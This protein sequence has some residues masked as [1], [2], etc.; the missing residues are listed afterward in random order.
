MKNV[1][2]IT[3]SLNM[4]GAERWVLTLAANF[5]RV[6]THAILNTLGKFSDTLYEEAK[7]I[8][9]TYICQNEYALINK[10]CSEADVIISWGYPYLSQ[11]QVDKPIIEVSHSDPVW[12]SQTKLIKQTIFGATHFVGVSKT[13][14]SAFPEC[15]EATTIYNGI[16]LERLE[17]TK[18]RWDTREGWG[19]NHK[20]L[21]LYLGG[22]KTVK[23]P[24]VVIEAAK[25]LPPEYTVLYV[26]NKH[27]ES[28]GIKVIRPDTQVG[29][30]YNAADVLVMPSMYEGMPLVLLEA[31]AH[32][33]PTV[34]TEYSAYKELSALHGK[35]SWTTQVSPT[36][37]MLADQIIEAYNGLDTNITRKAQH[38]VYTNYTTQHMVDRWENY[39]LGILNDS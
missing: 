28:K 38:V 21:V 12:P 27:F 11:L 36:P 39:L 18:S 5:A 2:F 14:A 3:P 33:I 25:I 35:L 6:R 24:K 10:I 26:S 32:G 4:G 9:P 37:Q 29:N 17:H 8:C 19:L 15:C 31:W 20:R 34:T 30:L 16:D 23:N 22:D 13:A 1:V 7:Q